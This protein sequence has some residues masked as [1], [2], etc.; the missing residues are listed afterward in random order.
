MN[1]F[2]ND[3]WE[4][5]DSWNTKKNSEVVLRSQMTLHEGRLPVPHENNK[6]TSKTATRLDLWQQ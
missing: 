6:M 4:T 3:S 2:L 5:H 1:R